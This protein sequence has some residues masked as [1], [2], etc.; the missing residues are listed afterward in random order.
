MQ[1]TDSLTDSLLETR[2]ELQRVYDESQHKTYF[3]L[4]IGADP[5]TRVIITDQ[6]IETLLQDLPNVLS[7]VIHSQVLME[8]LQTKEE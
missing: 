6:N 2:I 1:R 7:T 8:T 3:K 4:I 5:D